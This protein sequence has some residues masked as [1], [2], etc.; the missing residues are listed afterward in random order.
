MMKNKDTKR[1]LFWSV[2]T[3]LSVGTLTGCIYC[4]PIMLA[5]IISKIMHTTV[6][7]FIESL[8]IQQ[9]S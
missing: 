2:L 7:I 9:L 6:R 5:L 8:Q 4:A 3:L 1:K